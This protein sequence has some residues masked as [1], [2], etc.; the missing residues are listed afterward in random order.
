[1]ITSMLKT[2]LLAEE[3]TNLFY[4]KS[5]KIDLE[6]QGSIEYWNRIHEIQDI[7]TN[8]IQYNELTSDHNG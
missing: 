2:Q 1:M 5:D 6:R 8:F 3:I 7:I 4:L